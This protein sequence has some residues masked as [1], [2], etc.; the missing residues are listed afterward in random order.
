MNDNV[1][2]N[3]K[4]ITEQFGSQPVA[5]QKIVTPPMP[6]ILIDDRDKQAFHFCGIWRGGKKL[7]VK[8]QHR[9]LSVGSYTLEGFEGRI[10]I[11][12]RPA[13]T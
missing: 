10:G 2:H 11:K 8:T 6:T 7:E 9:R 3:N 4:A 12:R 13:L 5:A 1:I